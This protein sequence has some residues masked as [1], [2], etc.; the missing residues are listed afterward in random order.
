MI[1]LKV[2]V[3]DAIA[4]LPDMI[5]QF[6]HNIKNIYNLGARSFWVYNTRP[7]GCFPAIL[8]GFPSAE[9]DSAGC[10]KP[11]NKLAQHYNMELKKAL[12]QLRNVYPLATI[13]YVDIYSALCS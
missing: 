9:K 10:A 12:A 13:V 4:P 7:I 5:N 8:A 2:S 11:Y 6:I 3:A 1:S